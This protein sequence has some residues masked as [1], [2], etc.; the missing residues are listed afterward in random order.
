M[1]RNPAIDL[2][3]LLLMMGIVVLHLISMAQYWAQMRHVA[4]LLLPCVDGFVLI[5]G[6]FGLRF[7]IRKIVML[8]LVAFW[9]LL[10]VRGLQYFLD[11]GLQG[12]GTNASACLR[13]FG[14]CM[15]MP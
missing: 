13:N 7:S 1:K 4:Y 9:S 14:F 5:T 10:M 6:Y 12:G 15:R 11:G 8:Y 2:F 3:R